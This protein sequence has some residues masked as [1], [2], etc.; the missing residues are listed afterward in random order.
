MKLPVQ[1][2]T[3]NKPPNNDVMYFVDANGEDYHITF[4]EVWDTSFIIHVATGDKVQMVSAEIQK[5]FQL[6]NI[7]KRLTRLE[8]LV[9]IPND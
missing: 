3:F 5:Q 2:Y 9:G 8:D 1:P 7:E 4:D 6:E